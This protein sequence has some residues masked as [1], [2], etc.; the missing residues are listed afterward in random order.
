M[1]SGVSVSFAASS[2]PSTCA[3]LRCKASPLKSA[4]RERQSS[5]G[6]AT[7]G[8]TET[9]VDAVRRGL[10]LGY[11]LERRAQQ[12]AAGGALEIVLPEAASTGPAFFAHYTS[13]KQIEPGSR[14]F[15][16]MIRRNE[17]IG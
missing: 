10:G 9:T 15:I 4:L 8:D 1:S 16:A 5:A 14:Q 11:V 6:R 7:A 17:G 2:Q 12:E 3:G 13:R